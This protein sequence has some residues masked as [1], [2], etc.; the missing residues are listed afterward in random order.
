M[1]S[2]P[3][4]SALVTGGSGGIGAAVVR[5]LAGAG[6]RVAFTHLG[7]AAEARALERSL[8]GA[9][10]A[11]ESDCADAAAVDQ[12]HRELA[13]LILVCCAGIT[14]DGVIWKLAPEDFDAVLRVNLRG[15]W[16]SLHAA[17]PAMRAAGFG[18]I[19]LIGSINGSRGKAGQTAYAAGKAG[20][21]GLARSAAREL[22]RH[23]VTVNVIEPGWIDTPMTSGLSPGHRARA[24][25]ETLTGRLGRPEDVAAATVFL[26]SGEAGQITGQVLRVDG[27]QFLGCS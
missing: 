18:R 27:G 26:C 10:R 12:L 2:A 24:E 9:A 21:V 3:G 8:A 19:V 5:A 23:G 11:F 1:S 13:P 25:A 15:P 4:R 17:A 7:Q 20:L 22:G 14:R 6:H 16:L